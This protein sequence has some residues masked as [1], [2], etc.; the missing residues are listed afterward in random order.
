MA[1][2]ATEGSH[3][4]ASRLERSSVVVVAIASLGRVCSWGGGFLNISR[5]TNHQ[6]Y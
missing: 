4:S 5:A 6:H 3:F 1:L 2:D